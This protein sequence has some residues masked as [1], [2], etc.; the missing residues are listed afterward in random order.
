MRGQNAPRVDQAVDV[1]GSR[2]P[3]DE[4]HVLAGLAALLGGVR[5]EDDRAGGRAGRRVQA[6][7]RDLDL[8]ARVDPRMEELVELRRIDARNRLVA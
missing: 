1:V 3:A 5:V 6:A 2:L 4:D 8:R 7:R